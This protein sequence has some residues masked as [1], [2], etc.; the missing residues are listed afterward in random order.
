MK[1]ISSAG[2]NFIIDFIMFLFMM[3]I[4]GVGFMIKY[5]LVPGFKRNEI[6]GK[7]VELF[8]WGLDRHQ[9]GS[10][11][12]I[13]S[14]FF[15]FLLLLHIVLHWKQIIC[16]YK[17][18]VSNK[19]RR[20]VLTTCFVIISVILVMIPL[21]TRP[22]ID[23]TTYQDPGHPGKSRSGP[24]V[25]GKVILK[26]DVSPGEEDT[27][28]RDD[29]STMHKPGN[30]RMRRH[31]RQREIEV[32]GYMTIQEVAVKYN[33]SVSELLSCIHLPDRLAN[34]RLGRLKRKYHFK[35]DELRDYVENHVRK[36]NN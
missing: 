4:A 24:P 27:N 23:E 31:D 6:Y 18:M 3:A 30:G 12:L 15:F 35:L 2:L 13:L 14:F 33:L 8:F 20:A 21:F 29:L 19:K 9:W 26:S 22:E 11:H 28:S 32:H 36:D 10:I 16:V 34:Q 25:T 1:K 7:D 5:V 17:R